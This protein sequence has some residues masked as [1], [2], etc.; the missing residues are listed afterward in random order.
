MD[1]IQIQRCLMFIIGGLQAPPLHLREG[2]PAQP[3]EGELSHHGQGHALRRHPV[4]FPRTLQ[5]TAWRPLWI[6][7]K[8]SPHLCCHLFIIIIIIQQL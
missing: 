1:K 6:P 3:V 8:V 4:L 2:R 7:G 5:S